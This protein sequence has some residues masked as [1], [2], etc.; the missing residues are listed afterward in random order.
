LYALVLSKRYGESTYLYTAKE[1][2]QEALISDANSH[3][4]LD[5]VLKSIQ[6]EIANIESQKNG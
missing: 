4:N 2:L 6:N 3:K 1:R 5:V